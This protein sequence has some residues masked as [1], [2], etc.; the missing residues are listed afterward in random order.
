MKT[1]LFKKI[2]LSFLCIGVGVVSILPSIAWAA[3]VW[4]QAPSYE[5]QF[6]NKLLNEKGVYD[7]KDK[8]NLDRTKS[9]KDNIT[10]LFSP[11][12]D[13]SLIWEYI[14]E[15]MIGITILFIAWA[16]IDFL[17]N[18]NNPAKLKSARMSLL[19]ILAWGFL[20]Y[21]A[22]WIVG[23]LFNLSGNSG[24]ADVLT[25]TLTQKLFFTILSFLKAGA[26]FLAIIMAVVYG[27]Q[28][29]TAM[30]K[31]ELA[32][33]ARK[34]IMNILLALVGMK[35]IDFIYFIAQEQTFGTK[36]Q[37]LLL[38]TAKI[39]WWGM[40]AIMVAVLIYGWFRYISAQGDEAKAKD[41]QKMI[42]KIFYAV[43]I[44]FMFLLITR[45][46]IDAFTK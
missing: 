21:A 39:L 45:Q 31:D 19:Y 25:Y 34:G 18:T 32:T 11:Q 9:L 10:R 40:G 7:A 1:K 46:I 17:L 27:Y 29:I 16:G 42:I 35:V 12:N 14:K 15:I 8:F 4:T 43:L 41:A 38:N 44:V 30:D 2:I 3:T 6:R 26:F 28:M 33:K 13:K 36:L 24:P 20:V 23:S 37:T 22:V 5:N